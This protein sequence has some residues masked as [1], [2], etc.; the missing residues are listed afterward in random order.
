M[1]AAS[2]AWKNVQERFILP[3]G[4]LEITCAITETGAQESVSAMAPDEESYSRLTNAIAPGGVT[5][6][7]KYATNELNLWSLD[8]SMSV[9][10]D[11]WPNDVGYVSEIGDGTGIIILALQE[12]RTVA[13]PGITITWSSEHGE[14]PT[15]FKVYAYND[16]GV[17]AEK[18]VTGNKDVV[19]IVDMEL[20]NYNLIAI[21]VLEW[22]LPYRRLR[23]E[24]AALGHILTLNKGEILSFTHEQHGDL[25]SGELPKNSVQF[26]FDNI[27]GRW[28]PANPVGM[29]KYLSERQKVTVRYGFDISGSIEWVDAGVFYLSEW[30]APANGLEATFSARDVLEYLLN[31]PYTGI[32][33]GTLKALA[34]AA[35]AAAD[36]PA[37]VGVV[38]DEHLGSY[39]G[40][41][42]MGEGE[43]LTC[44]EV[45]QMCANAA[46][47]VIFQDRK[48]AL[49]I[50]RLNPEDSG[51]TISS[52]L[53]YA[54][55]EVDLSK[56]LKS[57]SVSYGDNTHTLS[58][59]T[60]GETQTVNN[61]LVSTSTQA[62]EIAEWVRDT[63]VARKSLSGE[64]R[65]DPRL[66]LFDIV[67][68]ESKYGVISPVA[69]THI[70]YDYNGAFVGSYTGRLI[71]EEGYIARSGN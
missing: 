58:V 26:S 22:C 12:V 10:P 19:S 69:I 16:G 65:A 33:S 11:N 32:T 71:S 6:A 38:F 35:M 64:Y 31:T 2:Q 5:P 54:H 21:E 47:C 63:L 17:I 55:P 15:S 43:K 46:S 68:V 30:R 37:D 8:G 29:E 66:D 59:D 13:I 52:N 62:A 25:N 36:V 34:E 18:T 9:F 51:Y 70:K 39:T 45:L 4:Y 28:N 23:M 27:D 57:V 50:E 1:I 40:T 7:N 48:G 24:R 42:Q 67:Q 56:P 49:H 20:V 53:S 44:A 41:I 14:Y 3:E 60:A 61:P